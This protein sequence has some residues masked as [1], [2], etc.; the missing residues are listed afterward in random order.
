MWMCFFPI[1]HQD[2]LQTMIDG[3]THQQLSDEEIAAHSK[4]LLLAGFE[5]TANLLAYTSYILALNPDKQEKLHEEIDS[6]FKVNPV[7]I[8]LICRLE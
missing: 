1:Q 7:R 8:I 3:N 6:Y 2:V 4:N 5:S